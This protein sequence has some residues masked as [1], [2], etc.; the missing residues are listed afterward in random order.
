CFQAEDGI[1]D[2][3]VTGVQTVLFRSQF[4]FYIR[5]PDVERELCGF[6]ECAEQDEDDCKWCKRTFLDLWQGFD[7]P[8]DAESA[9]DQVE[10]DESTEHEEAAEHR[11]YHRFQC[12][13]QRT[14]TGVPE[15]DEQETGD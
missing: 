15:C 4:P 9:C 12:T 13:V 8:S 5:Q 1:R 11:D 10:G 14:V 3:N 6:R 7:H 2:R